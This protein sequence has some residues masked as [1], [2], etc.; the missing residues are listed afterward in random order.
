[1]RYT[2]LALTHEGTTS[3]C[4][5]PKWK[6]SE[7]QACFIPRLLAVLIFAPIDSVKAVKFKRI[8]APLS[9]V[10]PPDSLI[11]LFDVS[12]VFPAAVCPSRSKPFV[13]AVLITQWQ[14]R[15]DT[16]VAKLPHAGMICDLCRE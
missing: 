13:G 2:Q 12:G 16:L 14:R 1:M 10:Y 9:L 4:G 15:R 3:I 11:C 5:G 6:F 7:V 8:Y